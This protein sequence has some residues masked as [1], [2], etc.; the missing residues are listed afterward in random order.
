MSA[1]NDLIVR[2]YFEGQGFL[3][4]Q[5]CK[6]SSQGR[7]K[8]PEEEIDL[9]VFN[10]HNRVPEISSQLIWTGADLRG[11]RGAVVAVRGWHSE[12]FSANTFAKTPELL[13]FADADVVK[14]AATKLGT[15]DVAKIL[16]LTQLPASGDL[17]AKTLEY[18][19]SRG[20]DGILS[21]RQML[22]E[23]LGSIEQNHNYD[24]S[25]VLQM[26]RI[27]KSSGLVRDNQM[28]LFPSSKPRRKSRGP[29]EP[30]VPEDKT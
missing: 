15:T 5:P 27:L 30:V 3:V 26:L 18:L 16:C 7:A 28:E 8:K 25:D 14:K 29:L 24:K 23:L 11:V 10:P 1:V 12:R 20:V 9:V 22:V 2:E 19:K 17:K 4:S 13:R 21:F 6:Y